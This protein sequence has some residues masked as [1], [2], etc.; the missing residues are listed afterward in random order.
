MSEYHV[1]V[2]VQEMLGMLNL[3]PGKIALD[4]TLGGGSQA[5]EIGKQIEPGGTLVVIDQDPEAFEEAI[6][7]LKQLDVKLI[8]L[9]GNFRD[10]EKMLKIAGLSSVDAAMIDAGVSSRQLDSAERGF[11]MKTFNPFSIA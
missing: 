10:L 4:C 6:P 5:F 7:K 9:S 11:S 1:P 3:S 2:M 8:P